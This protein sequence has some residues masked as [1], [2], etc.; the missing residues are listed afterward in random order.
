MVHPAERAQVRVGDTT[1]TYLPDGHARLDPAVLFPASQPEGWATH[2]AYL[3]PDG[4]F[5]V[6]IGSFLL[7]TPQRAILVDL[8]LGAVDFAVPDVATFTGGRLLE[9]LAAEGLHPTDIDT[10][11][12]THLHHDHVG[13]TTDLAPAPDAAPDRAVTGLTFPRARHLV[14]ATE[15]QHWKGTDELVGP[16]PTAVQNPL[17]D[18][19]A[20]VTDGAEIAPGVR[21]LA[22]P[23]HTPGHCS[24]TVSDPTG[25]D[26][27]KVVVLGDVM[28]CQVQVTES[29]WS[30]LFDHDAQQ[31]T[32]TREHLLDQLEDPDT[33]IAGGHFAGNVFGRVLPPT[34][35]RAWAS[36]RP[37]LQS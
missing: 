16:H 30:F 7:R 29:H 26:H 22:T 4:R 21:V 25:H 24:L 18:V 35:R 2:A 17:A 36:R 10:V 28:H 8:G 34:A 20:F 37:A 1:I 5:P 14:S 32:R 6:S 23:G 11:F 9:S 15:W 3:D 13:W 19:I 27:Q 12:F 31:A 33:T